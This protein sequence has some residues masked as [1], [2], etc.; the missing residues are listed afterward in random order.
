MQEHLAIL[1]RPIVR[2]R[3]VRRV[4]VLFAFFFRDCAPSLLMPRLGNSCV[5]HG[6]II[7]SCLAARRYKFG[8]AQELLRPS[9]FQI[10]SNTTRLFSRP[11][12]CQFPS[13]LESP[14]S[15]LPP[16]VRLCR[17]VSSCAPF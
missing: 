13:S 11:A 14:F 15:H 16:D 7:S 2:I 1:S 4:L 6:F 12:C 3:T 17:D 9:V 8:S 10:S 5:I